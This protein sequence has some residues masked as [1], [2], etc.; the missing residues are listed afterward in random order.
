MADYL[1]TYHGPAPRRGDTTDLVVYEITTEDERFRVSALACG[2]AAASS[3][4]RD[5][6]VAAL[7]RRAALEEIEARLAAGFFPRDW[8]SAGVRTTLTYDS[9]DVPAL[10][11]LLDVRKDCLWLEAVEPRG[12]VCAA[13]QPDS[14]PG[15]TPALCDACSV[16]ERALV[17]EALV[18]PEVLGDKDFSGRSRLV[19]DVQCEADKDISDYGTDCIP[20]GKACWHRSITTGRPTPPPDSGAPSRV[21]DEIGY[22]RLVYADAFGLSRSETKTFWPA[23]G[24]GAVNSLRNPCRSLADFRTH[25]VTLCEVLLGM[26]PHGQL[27]EDRRKVDDRPVNGITA[28]QR[29][30]KDRFDD[31]AQDGIQLL[32]ELN[33]ARNRFSHDDRKELLAA[34]RALGVTAYPPQSCEVSWWQVA[35]SVADGLGQ[36][37]SAIQ[38]VAPSALPET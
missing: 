26:K 28:L 2:S 37:R 10:E 22:L 21:V 8:G 16:P 5:A 33:V 1:I 20:G 32:L 25:V 7:L 29:V 38:S 34:L 35:A 3:R 13:T 19:T 12:H 27:S 18:F 9:E 6:D 14:D 31:A 30:M 17:C 15:T 11:A 23:S 4:L 24:E 36:I